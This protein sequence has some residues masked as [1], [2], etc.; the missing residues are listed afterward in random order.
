MSSGLSGLIFTSEEASAS[1]AGASSA[2]PM[3]L[4]AVD[5]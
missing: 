5:L 2:S 3:S 1:V 4:A